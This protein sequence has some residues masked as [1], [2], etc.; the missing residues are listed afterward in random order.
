MNIV[1]GK[2]SKL[3]SPQGELY[4]E[5]TILEGAGYKFASERG[6][7]EGEIPVFDPE[8]PFNTDRHRRVRLFGIAALSGW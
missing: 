5:E 4:F 6:I 2:S 7:K 1:T 8:S 3:K